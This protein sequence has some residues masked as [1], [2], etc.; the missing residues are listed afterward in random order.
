MYLLPHFTQKLAKIKIFT[1]ISQ[2]S[3]HT[4]W[5]NQLTTTANSLPAKKK[6]KKTP[7]KNEKKPTPPDS[8]NSGSNKRCLSH[9]CLQQR[10]KPLFSSSF[11]FSFSF[12]F[13]KKNLR[14]GMR[15]QTFV[16]VAC[17]CCCGGGRE[18]ISCCS[19]RHWT[20]ICG[21]LGRKKGRRSWLPCLNTFENIVWK[22]DGKKTL[23]W[24]N[25]THT[26]KDVLCL[27]ICV[28]QLF[29]NSMLFMYRH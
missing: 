11:S 24:R 3:N 13:L 4:K 26:K 6:K 2:T 18:R 25:C 17:C 19:G 9:R 21:L 7:E 14:K 15:G 23:T 16:V 29:K 27:K 1:W 12:F 28:V 8:P 5:R 22:V 10:R 20:N